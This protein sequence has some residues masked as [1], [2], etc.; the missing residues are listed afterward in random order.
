MLYIVDHSYRV[1]SC[2]QQISLEGRN[3]VMRE[4]FAR[5]NMNHVTVNL[6]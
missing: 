3:D 6:N 5:D 2:W 1:Y 4:V